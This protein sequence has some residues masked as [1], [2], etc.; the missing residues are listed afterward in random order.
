M[1]LAE[2]WQRAAEKQDVQI[3]LSAEEQAAEEAR[4]AQVAAERDAQLRSIH[5]Q[6]AARQYFCSL[7]DVSKVRPA[8]RESNVDALH[9][10]HL[11]VVL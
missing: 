1:K 10:K 7:W 5:R 8:H 6:E 9:R 3:V 4:R 2:L 11:C